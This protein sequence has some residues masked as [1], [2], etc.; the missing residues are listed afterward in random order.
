MLSTRRL[1]VELSW[2]FSYISMNVISPTITA[3]NTQATVIIA[4]LI[5]IGHMSI[6]N[7]ETNNKMMQSFGISLQNA[8]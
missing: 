5:L 3:I 6:E 7:D 1:I 8:K 4:A 2:Y